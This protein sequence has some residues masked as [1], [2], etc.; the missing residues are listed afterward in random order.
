MNEFLGNGCHQLFNGKGQYGENKSSKFDGHQDRYC[1]ESS[2]RIT[3][4]DTSAAVPFVEGDATAAYQFFNPD[5]TSYKRKIWFAN[6]NVFV[7]RDTATMRTEQDVTWLLHTTFETETADQSFSII[8]E[9]A[10]L[11]VTFINDSKDEIVSIETVEG[12]GDVDPAEYA[13]LEV[14][15]HVETIFKAKKE[16][17]ILTLLVP[18]KAGEAKVD[19]SYELNGDTLELIIDGEPVTIQL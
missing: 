1:I 6:G 10:V 3:D 5:L 13:D 4:Y 16:H 15:R 11:D 17:D 7:M 18:S 14:H 8:G 2:G 12:F 9:R 19:V